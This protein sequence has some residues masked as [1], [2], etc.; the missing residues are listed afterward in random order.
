MKKK[1][2]LLIQS[3]ETEKFVWQL[4]KDGG[5][6]ATDKNGRKNPARVRYPTIS[7]LARKLGI[8]KSTLS[9]IILA[10]EDRGNLSMEVDFQQESGSNPESLTYTDFK[11]TRALEDEPDLRKQLL[12][13]RAEKKVTRDDLRDLVKIIN[14]IAKKYWQIIMQI[15][16]QINQILLIDTHCHHS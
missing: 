6:D 11:A 3:I 4:W 8:P 5:P 15:I 2:N 1:W 12:E 14:N 7:A 13:L 16:I 9:D 10:H